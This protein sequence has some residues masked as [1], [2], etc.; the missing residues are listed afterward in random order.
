MA[1]DDRIKA[2][3]SELDEIIVATRSAT[4]DILH[5][6]E[7]IGELLDEILARHSTDEKLYALTEEAGQELVNIMEACSFQ[8]ITGQ[9]VNKIGKTIRYIQDRIVAMIRYLGRGSD[10]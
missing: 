4:V 9:R 6:A 2:E 5:S 7:H 10:H 3:S 8:D 1:D